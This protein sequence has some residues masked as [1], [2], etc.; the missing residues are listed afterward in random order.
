MYTAFVEFILSE[1]VNTFIVT[2]IYFFVILCALCIWLIVDI[3]QNPG[4]VAFQINPSQ[5]IHVD[6]QGFSHDEVDIY[7]VCT[8]TIVVKRKGYV[9]RQK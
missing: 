8:N 7:Q 9:N 5:C 3:F 2:S 6:V 1:F 4:P